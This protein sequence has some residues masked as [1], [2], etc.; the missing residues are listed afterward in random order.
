[1]P[2]DRIYLRFDARFEMTRLNSRVRLC[3]THTSRL[4]AVA[5]VANALCTAPLQAATDLEALI[6]QTAS[7]MASADYATKIVRT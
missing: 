1:M 5:T 7:T 2:S 6:S 4:L 3:R